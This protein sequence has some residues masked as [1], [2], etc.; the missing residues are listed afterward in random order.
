[1]DKMH[2]EAP[3]IYRKYCH[4]ELHGVYFA[5]FNFLPRRGDH[6]PGG[7]THGKGILL[8]GLKKFEEGTQ[9]T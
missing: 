7:K 6:I 4:C 8:H 1:M 3:V 2:G 5:Y 9:V